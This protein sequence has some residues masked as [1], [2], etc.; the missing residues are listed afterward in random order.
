M[1]F[2]FYSGNAK[3]YANIMIQKKVLTHLTL[4][5]IAM[6]TGEFLGNGLET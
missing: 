3:F 6:A 4:E 2:Q 1:L 5:F